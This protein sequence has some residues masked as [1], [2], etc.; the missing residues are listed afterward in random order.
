MLT[1]QLYGTTMLCCNTY[2]CF[3]EME[4]M[5]K[6]ELNEFKYVLLPISY[7]KPW[8]TQYTP[9]CA[10]LHGNGLASINHVH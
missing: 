8:S 4:C 9:A 5:D 7:D 10:G 6:G 1:V 3:S 2:S